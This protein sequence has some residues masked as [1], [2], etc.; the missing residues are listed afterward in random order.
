MGSEVARG[1]FATKNLEQDLGRLLQVIWVMSNPTQINWVYSFE[2][3]QTVP[4][5]EVL[6]LVSCASH[7][8]H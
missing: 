6:L 2:L 4:L 8:L 7:V 3:V 1:C 5:N